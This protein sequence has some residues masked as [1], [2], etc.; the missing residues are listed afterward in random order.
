MCGEKLLALTWL[1]GLGCSG[2]CLCCDD[3][4]GLLR[5]CIAVEGTLQAYCCW[6]LRSTSIVAEK[7]T[8]HALARSPTVCGE[9]GSLWRVLESDK[10]VSGPYMK[11]K[12]L[13]VNV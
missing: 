6:L 2:T 4:R 11:T 10:A 9:D 1:A 13:I 3:Q 12:T 5:A 8:V 7:S